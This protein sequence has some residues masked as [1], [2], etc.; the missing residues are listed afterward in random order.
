MPIRLS[1][2]DIRFIR[3]ASG[4]RSWISVNSWLDSSECQPLCHWL[5]KEMNVLE[6]PGLRESAFP[7]WAENLAA[8]S[9]FFLSWRKG[10]CGPLYRKQVLES[11]KPGL[12]PFLP[13]TCYMLGAS[14]CTSCRVKVLIYNIGWNWAS[15]R[16]IGRIKWYN[17]CQVPKTVLRT[18]AFNTL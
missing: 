5:K 4:S 12:N 15:Y 6:I 9:L 7:L 1:I 13:L 14:W 2:S 18:Q 10:H 17:R 3:W 8:W 16:A 11:P